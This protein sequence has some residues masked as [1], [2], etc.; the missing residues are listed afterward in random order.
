MHTGCAATE[1][2]KNRL[3]KWANKDL[4]KFNS[5]EQKVLP[6][7]SNNLLHQNNLGT[8]WLQS[9]FLEEA[10]GLLLNTKVTTSQQCTSTARKAAA[11][12]A[13]VR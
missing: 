11:S 8:N 3:E 6:L 1:R 7:G 13:G 9:R 12:L 5:G 4:M 10:L 2:H